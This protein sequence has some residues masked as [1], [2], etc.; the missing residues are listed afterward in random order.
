[1]KP[2]L[3]YGTFPLFFLGFNG[4]ALALIAAGAG[5]A[6][7]YALLLLALGTMLALERAIPWQPAWNQSHDD[8][9]SDLAHAAVNTLLSYAL[10]SALPLLT[11]LAPQPALWPTHWP[12]LAQV[13]VAVLVLDLGIAAVHHASH[14]IGGLW[15]FHAIH[16]GATRLYGF[17][18]WMK[19]PVHQL[20][21]TGVGMT[22]LLLLGVTQPVGQA[23]AFAVAIQLLLQHS[24]ADLRTGPLRRVFATAEVH[25]FHHA[26]G[27]AGD[28][29][30]GLFTTLWD[31]LAGSFRDA[32][33]TAP[34]ERGSVGLDGPV[35]SR[36]YRREL[37]KPFG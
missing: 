29:N 30:F 1:M 34:R 26:R 24:N 21:E 14:R 10:V 33:G 12:F 31:H 36:R 6:T 11:A 37:A 3:R 5:D 16:H 20:L 22:P 28:V 27:P 23:V 13:V 35:E 7:R 2:L 8:V 32:P 9:A 18:G 15:R 19:H 4:I 17:N 25:R